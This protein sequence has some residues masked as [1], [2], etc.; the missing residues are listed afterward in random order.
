LSQNLTPRPYKFTIGSEDWSD[1]LVAFDGADTKINYTDG[2]V[3]FRGKATIGRPLGFATLDDRKNSLFNRGT[4]VIIEFRDDS[5]ALRRSPRG[6]YLFILSSSYDFNARLNTIELGDALAL[7][8]VAEGKGDRTGIC[9]GVGESR[10]S[11]INRLLKAAGAPLLIDEIPGILS[12]PLPKL[13]EGSYIQQAGQITASAGYFLYVDSLNQVR[14][15][16]LNP[17]EIASPI[18]I[19]LSSGAT[20]IKRLTGESPAQYVFAKM[21]VT[22]AQNV[23]NGTVFESETFGP[24]AI[25]G[26]AST[27]RILARRERRTEKLI[28]NRREVSTLVYEPAGAVIKKLSGDAGLIISNEIQEIYYYETD[29]QVKAN[30]LAAKC[31]T[32]NQARLL[33]RELRSWRPYGAILVRVIASLPSNVSVSQAPLILD[34]YEIETFNYDKPSDVIIP[35]RPVYDRYEDI[36]PQAAKLYGLTHSLERS[37]ARGKVSPEDYLYEKNNNAWISADVVVPFPSYYVHKKW[38]EQRLNEWVATEENGDAFARAYSEDANALR[39]KFKSGNFIYSRDTFTAAILVSK[40]T[41]VSSNGNTQPPSPDTMPP[42]VSVDTA[43]ITGKASFPIDSSYQFR[44]RP[45]DITFDYVDIPG[46]NKAAVDSIRAKANQLAAIWGKVVWGRFKGISCSTE[47]SQQ[48]WDYSP[49]DRINIIETTPGINYSEADTSAYL[50][51]GFAIAITKQ[52]CFIGFD[53]IYLGFLKSDQINPPYKQ[54]FINDLQ[55]GFQ[56]SYKTTSIETPLEP[57]LSSYLIQLGL[58][59][60]YLAALAAPTSVV[61]T[62][63]STTPYNLA[64]SWT[65]TVLTSGQTIAFYEIEYKNNGTTNIYQSTK[66]SSTTTTIFTGLAVGIFQA[67]VRTVDTSGRR[68][69]WSESNNAEISQVPAITS[70]TAQS[71]NTAPVAGATVTLTAIVTG[72]GAFSSDVIWTVQPASTVTGTI[73]TAGS[74]V[75]YAIPSNAAVGTSRLR[76]TSVQ[77]STKFSEILLSVQAKPFV[78]V[79]MDIVVE[80][81]I[82]PRWL[83]STIP[84][85]IAIELPL[86]TLNPSIAIPMDIVIDLKTTTTTIVPISMDIVVELPITTGAQNLLV[87][88]PMA[89]TQPPTATTITANTAIPIGTSGYQFIDNWYAYSAD[90]NPSVLQVAGSTASRVQVSG[91]AGTTA[92]GIGQRIGASKSAQ[93]SG[94][95]AT[96]SVELSNS[97][98]SSVAWSAFY[99]STTPAIVATASAGNDPY[100]AV[101]CPSND[102]LYVANRGSSTV[103]VVN[104]SIN[105]VVA[106][107]GVGTNPF[108]M[109]YCPTSGSIYVANLTSNNV[110]V[111]NPSINAVVATIGVEVNPLGVTYCPSNDRIYASNFGSNSVSVINPS[112]NAVVATIVVGSSPVAAA[113]SPTADRLYVSNYSGD[114]ISVINPSTNAVVATIGVGS[115]PFGSCNCTSTDR[116]YVSNL[117]SNTVSVINPSTNA[118]VGTIAVGSGPL[119]CAYSPIAD[120]VYVANNG[121]NNVSVINPS[122]NTVISTIV[123]GTAPRDI[124]FSSATSKFYVTN[125]GSHT[126]TVIDPAVADFGTIAAP[127]KTQIASGTFT[128]NSSVSSFTSTFACDANVQNGIEILFAVGAQTSGTWVIGNARLEVAP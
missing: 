45:L 67:R 29:A 41:T 52:E 50:G 14:A 2:L 124:A 82:V 9:L 3:S 128:V 20:E 64:I 77:D 85:D 5:S 8:S 16:V 61:A 60:Q 26:I 88:G 97:L 22:I 119:A 58:Q 44:P 43:T 123:V 46:N 27:S 32:G 83:S 114:N 75:T 108:N 66:Q 1:G 23:A 35:D 63:S 15:K 117:S 81:P 21:Q 40:T 12:V 118:V 104:L 79:S 96:L 99:P 121:S 47:F 109:A 48:W 57:I 37:E 113:Y 91:A 115:N 25:A 74:N 98:L 68:S 70:V 59:T 54:V 102:R 76:A 10:R 78:I 30:P 4:P 51:D 112:T 24:A 86:L 11:I 19:D 65:A 17:D 110:S 34:T 87:N 95:S 103:S 49:L 80:L 55:L 94:R 84:M 72:L 18:A 38:V 7:L 100:G 101:Y 73:T 31:E 6:G 116:I 53:G 105:A 111:I 71:S 36:A 126:V 62:G 28:E 92:I 120:R 122:T 56:V 93:L 39:Q 69:P 42:K 106:T 33:K 125:S 89:I 107:I 13:L 90:G 127:T